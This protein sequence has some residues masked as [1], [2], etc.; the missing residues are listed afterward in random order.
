MYSSSVFQV[1][2]NYNN[3]YQLHSNG[4]TWNL[5]NYELVTV[6]PQNDQS[7]LTLCIFSSHS[8]N[9]LPLPSLNKRHLPAVPFQNNNH[10]RLV[11]FFGKISRITRCRICTWRR[12]SKR[13]S[14]IKRFWKR[15][16]SLHP[17]YTDPCC[18]STFFVGGDD[19]R[20]LFSRGFFEEQ[21]GHL[22]K[23]RLYDEF[24]F[25]HDFLQVLFSL[26]LLGI[27]FI[28]I[29]GGCQPM[30]HKQTRI[31]CTLNA[32]RCLETVVPPQTK[33]GGV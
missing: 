16:V 30:N 1:P 23:I 2:N 18:W 10:R 12:P 9:S 32:E 5:M 19:H 27:V 31:M 20:S 25:L 14:D 26:L 6:T 17:L 15:M 4:H 33:K 24:L 28:T 21:K 22:G 13:P 8:G 7:D 3:W 11:P 29:W